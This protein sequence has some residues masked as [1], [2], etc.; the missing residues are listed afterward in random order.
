MLKRIISCILIAALTLS[1]LPMT[2]FAK[3]NNILYGDVNVDGEVD[4]NDALMLK[5][6]IAEYNPSGFSFINANVNED[7]EVDLTDLLMLKKYLA[8]WDICL[9]P[10]LLTVSFYDGDRLIDALVANKGYSLSEV[11]SSAKSSKADS[12]LVGYYTDEALTAPFYAENPVESSMEVYAKYE[13]M[14]SA[15]TVTPTS[16][17][18]M[19]M[20]TS[21]SFEIVRESGDT[22]P[23]T[24]AVLTVKDGSD[25]V[26]LVIEDSDGD[27]VYTV[28]APEGF[29]E[30]CSYELTLADG[31]SFNGKESSI[32]TAAFSIKKDI[33]KNLTMSGDTHF[34]RHGNASLLQAGDT[35]SADNVKTGD[36]ICFYKETNPRERDYTSGNAYMDDP[37]IWFKAGEVSG[38]EVTLEEMSEEDREKI[39]DVPDNFPVNGNMPSSDGGALTLTPEDGDGYALDTDVYGMMVEDN[40][41]EY[42]LSKVSVGDFVSIY[43]SKDELVSDSDV[44]FGKIVGFDSQTGVITFEKSSAEEIEAAADLYIKPVLSGDELISEEAKEEIEEEVLE[45]I[46]YSGFAE[47]AAYTL[48]NMAVYTDGFRSLKGVSAVF[49]DERGNTL[50]SNSVAARNI[51]KSFELKDGV[52]LTVEV[53]TSGDQMHFTDK[54]AVQ[55]AVGIDAQFEVDASDGGKI[56]IDLSAAFVQEISLGVTANGKLVTKEILWCIPVPIGVQVGASVD[57]KSF[58]GIRIDA[59]A[60]TEAAEDDGLMDQLLDIVKNP[61]SVSEILPDKLGELKKGLDTVGDIYDKIEELKGEMEQVRDDIEKYKGYVEDIA[62]LWEAIDEIG[63]LPNEDEWN[64]LCEKLN[65]TNISK[66]LM[67]MMSLSD[68]TELDGDRYAEDM[69][70]LMAKYSEMLQK[71]TDWVQ[72]V[73]KEMCKSQITVCGLVIEFGANFVVRADMNIAMG[74]NLQYEVGKRYNFWVKLGMFTPS[75]GSETMDLL[76][77]Q[78]AFQ[79]YVMGKLGLKMGIKGNIGFALGSPDVAS[80]SISLEFG[81]YI[82]LCGFFLYSYERTREANTTEFVSV[83]R[84]GGALYMEFGLY[85]IVSLDASAAGGLLEVSSDFLDE[86]Y[87]LL[88]AG[89]K[90]FAYNFSYDPESNEPLRIKDSDNDSTNGIE[91][92]LPSAYRTLRCVSLTDGG[93]RNIAY[94]Y[95]KYNITFSDPHFSLR[96]D[97]ANS[98]CITVEVPQGTQYI[99]CDMTV[100]YKGSKLAFSDRDMQVTVPIYWTNLT[101]DEA[102][103]EYTAGIRV[104]NEEDGYETVW[105]RL[106][107]K[108]ETF[109]LPTTEE[110]MELVGFSAD[111]YE[112]FS[113]PKAG[114]TVSLTEDTDYLCTAVY[115]PYTV[116]VTGIKNADGTTEKRTF[117]ARYGEKFDF[118]SLSDTGVNLPDS[119]PDLACFTKFAGVTTDAEIQVGKDENGNPVYSAIDLSQPV[120]G[121]MAEAISNG[122]VAVSAVYADDSVLVT[123]QFSGINV[124]NHVERIRKGT[125]SAFDFSAVAAENGMAVKSISPEQGVLNSSVTYIVECGEIIGEKYKLTF[126]ENGG[127]QVDDIERV[128]GALIGNLPQPALY[129]YTFTGWFTDSDCKIPFTERLMPKESVTL[130]AG[131]K[132]NTVTVTF[133]VNNGN[134]WESPEYGVRDIV[135]GEN[136]GEMPKATRTGNYGF[137][138]WYTEKTGGTL[139]TS[140]AVMNNASAHTLYAHWRELITIESEGKFTFEPL[141]DTYSGSVFAPVYGNV[142]T[143]TADKPLSA[144]DFIYRYKLQGSDDY[145][146]GKPVNV[147]V[148]DVVISREADDYYAAFEAYRQAVVKI[149]MAQFTFENQLTKDD[150]EIENPNPFELKV[151]LKESGWAKLMPDREHT[152]VVFSPKSPSTGFTSKVGETLFIQPP[153]SASGYKIV[154]TVTNPNYEISYSYTNGTVKNKTI[155]DINIGYTSIK[156]IYGTWFSADYYDEITVENNAFTITTPGQLAYIVSNLSDSKLNNSDI[157]YTLGADLDMSEHT[158]KTFSTGFR[159]TLDG[160]GHMIKGLYVNSTGSNCTAG[161]FGRLI[162]TVKN[163]RIENSAFIVDGFTASGSNSWSTQDFDRAGAIAGILDGTVENC[164]TDNVLIRSTGKK[165]T[166]GGMVGFMFDGSQIIGCTA[167]GISLCDKDQSLVGGIAGYA[168]G[169]S[170]ANCESTAD[171]KSGNVSYVGGIIGSVGNDN[172]FGFGNVKSVTVSGCKHTGS[173]TGGGNSAIG[174]IVGIYKDGYLTLE[175]NTFDKGVPNVECGN[176]S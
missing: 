87:P 36:L 24:A 175:N 99:G 170:V 90:I 98:A 94:D 127:S 149:N 113:F 146:D 153:T 171:V 97:R 80:V 105:T 82:K 38:N 124:P 148:Y 18:Q 172:H 10:E 102:N 59:Q 2:A 162:G 132:A 156:T 56:V 160:N 129:G 158:W 114:Q 68:E 163:L 19:D 70:D 73:D 140:E 35:V 27:G 125:A 111:K 84:M 133:D 41:L 118:S 136:Y 154:L 83:Q 145:I 55:L 12:I 95:D 51:S 81:P 23:Q 15:T 112:S 155:L 64:E 79:Y 138:G 25:S 32:R 45:Q 122:K 40:S 144:D 107:H 44:Y 85:L 75:A 108:G 174:G 101:Q 121:K 14:E 58:T 6:Y 159:A 104:G 72:L 48:A 115:K 9:G 61:K 143:G 86:E 161:L 8:E 130:Y 131:W 137:E 119:D 164:H 92:K 50:S 5:R 165:A 17:A 67:D 141:E 1:M 26:E 134:S 43:V 30:G 128:G 20:E 74:A 21:V 66:D 3:T 96:L 60:Y 11:P 126:N 57:I 4:L 139:V 52:A 123:Y 54:G 152:S 103:E 22:P 176:K 65:K 49:Y 91:M 31:W 135:F 34:I 88:E 16:F 157:V 47:E 120:T 69:E 110:L 7:D 76:D 173:V 77:E 53:I 117:T 78:F 39:Y 13:D 166:L 89:N 151:S 106:V 116:T 93:F 142:P 150:L 37:E 42:A 100:T 29:N 62:M 33:V 167:G 28:S 63:E 169:G 168:G 147:G 109:T 71:Q 46:R